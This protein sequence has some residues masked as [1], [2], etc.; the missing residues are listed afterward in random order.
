MTVVDCDGASPHLGLSRCSTDDAA[1][2]DLPVSCFCARGMAGW[3]HEPDDVES[4]AQ[5]VAPSEIRDASSRI[6]RRKTTSRHPGQNLRMVDIEQ[7]VGRTLDQL[8]RDAVRI[9]QPRADGMLKKKFTWRTSGLFAPE[10]CTGRRW[11]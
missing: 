10:L 7:A 9:V 2:A 6:P 4:L 1:R 11:P 8:G 5:S 3:R